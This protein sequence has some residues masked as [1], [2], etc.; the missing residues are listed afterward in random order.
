MRTLKESD[1]GSLVELLQLALQRGKWSNDPVDGVFGARTKQTVERLQRSH[2]LESDGIVGEKTWAA[3]HPLLTGF[4]THQVSAHETLAEIAGH[5]DTSLQ[6]VRTANPDIVPQNIQEGQKIKVPLP[7]AVVPTNIRWSSDLL[8]YV[9]EGLLARYPFLRHH[10]I[11]KSVM[12]R[13]L[14]Q[15]SIGDGRRR[16]GYNAS[17]HANEWITTPVLLKFLEQYALGVATNSDI[18][19]VDYMRLYHSY[20]L[21]I[22]PM[23]NPDGVD[24][25][26][27]A[28]H[29]GSPEVESAAK[30][31]AAFPAL[32]FP[33]G[34]KANIEG[35]DLNLNYPARW[36]EAKRIKYRQ[37]YTRP[38]PRDFVGMKPLD[39][40]EAAAMHKRTLAAEYKLILAYHSQG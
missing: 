25:V 20:T 24:L 38:A 28:L 4:V 3:L 32:P 11:G 36:E 18:G 34:W 19:G 17:H 39:A 10:T 6:A 29:P 15:L 33:E 35:V 7:M 40:P 9:T 27:N 23:V 1:D 2:D 31:A 26:T 12:G 21:D 8:G 14:H 22:V 16:V 13:S 30:I 37:G 5:Y